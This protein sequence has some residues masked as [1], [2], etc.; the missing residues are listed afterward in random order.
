MPHDY[1][2]HIRIINRRSDQEKVRLEKL[3]QIVEEERVKAIANIEA[4]CFESNGGHVDD[5]S[6]LHGKCKYCSYVFS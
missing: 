3:I 1:T 5:G 4:L 2:D 6:M